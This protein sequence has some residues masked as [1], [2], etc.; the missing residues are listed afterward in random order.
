MRFHRCF[1]EGTYISYDPAGPDAVVEAHPALVI[2]IL[3]SGQN[4]LV[5]QVVGPL[6]QDPGAAVHT[7]RVA[8]AEVG[9]ELG[10]VA[11]ALIIA[12]LEVFVFIKHNLEEK[13]G[14]SVDLPY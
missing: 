13:N 2:R 7:N 5:T 9:V 14:F 4:V 6:I 11:V 8:V 12:T 1:A 10:T 3:P